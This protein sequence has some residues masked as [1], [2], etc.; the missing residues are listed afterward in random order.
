MV[1]VEILTGEVPFDTPEWR[2][3]RMDEFLKHLSNGKRPY[4]P[5]SISDQFPWLPKIIAKAWHFEPDKRCNSLEM[6]MI[7]T[8]NIESMFGY[9]MK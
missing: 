9:Q 8:E 2:C 4:L 5:A 6:L 7:F 3:M 1:I